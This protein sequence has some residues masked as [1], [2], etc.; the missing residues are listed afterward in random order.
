VTRHRRTSF[1]LGLALLPAAVLA[2]QNRV[3][4]VGG[5]AAPAYVLR[6]ARVFDGESLHA[7]WAVVIRAGRIESA[8]PSASVAAG[9]AEP[10]E[11]PGLTILPG[12]ID[13]H[14]H[15]LLHPYDETVWTDQVLREPEALRVARAVNH[16]R[17]TL[18]AGFTTLRDLG[19]E[20]AGYAD[21]GLREAV[22][23]GIVPGPR[24]IV[25]TRAIVATGMYAPK[26]FSPALI[27]PQGAEEADGP[28][29][30]RVVRDQAGHGAD[31]IKV[32]G[33]YRAGPGGET[34]PTFSQ[35]EMTSIVAT[36]GSLGRPVAVHA[37]TAEG[38]RRAV[39]A[40]AATIE[41]GDDGTP[42]VFR[43]M[44]ERGVA[45]CP[46]L[47]ASESVAQY[48][49]WKKG[50]DPEPAA[51]QHKRE[52]FKAAVAAGVRIASGSDVGVFAHGDNARE[53]A[54]MVAYGMTPIA[55]LRAAT[56]DNARVLHLD[57]RI[58]RV[59]QG[60]EAD[61][62]GVAGDPTEDISAAARVQFV[63]QGGRIVRRP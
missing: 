2:A 25:T 33:D 3:H 47:T 17:A 12:L 14:S 21:V 44:A 32:Y 60:L 49:G 45:L 11:L 8:G 38:I 51:L 35:E 61:L 18:H 9:A 13:A 50:V 6:P 41:H 55:A 15:I 30:V 19:T 16:L 26:G 43:L 63:M 20:G 58:G 7:G 5:T 46:T 1:A 22:A 42:D 28:S 56:A 10:I 53:L 34:V 52:T 40:G 37:F 39:L 54:L 31:W 23:Q 57:T 29:L 4:P 62:V 59:A 27:V 48:A 36:A 24:L